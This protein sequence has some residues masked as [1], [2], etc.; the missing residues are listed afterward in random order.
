MC[1]FRFVV[2]AACVLLLTTA[3]DAQLP[4]S[5]GGTTRPV[6]VVLSGGMTLP[7]GDLADLHDTGFHYDASLLINLGGFPLTL[8]PEVSLA[9]LKL[10]DIVS[11]SPAPSA[12]PT[13]LVSALGNIEIPLTAGFYVLGGG[14]ILALTRTN[15]S[16]STA[17]DITANELT[18]NAG[19]GLRFRLGG[20]SGFVE[21]RVGTAS[22]DAGKVGFKSAQFIPVTFGLVF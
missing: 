18:F 12:D 19:A 6:R 20:A 17:N 10:K 13:Q 3:V 22:Y 2:I 14:G 9:R 16:S 21:A 4:Q 15:I 7:A 5:G 11:S 8:R 1:R